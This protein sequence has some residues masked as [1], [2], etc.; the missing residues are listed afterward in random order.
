[1]ASRGKIIGLLAE[2]VV[3]IGGLSI[4]PGL[5]A[6]TVRTSLSSQHRKKTLEITYELH[7]NAR[8]LKAVRGFIADERGASMDATTAVQKGYFTIA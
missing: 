7:L 3:H 2:R 1:M 5:Y 4:P 6:A 8:D